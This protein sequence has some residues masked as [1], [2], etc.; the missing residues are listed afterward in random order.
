M[1]NLDNEA[2]IRKKLEKLKKKIEK[3]F[4]DEAWFFPEINGVK[5]Y[6]GTGLCRLYD[7]RIMFIAER[8]STKRR[9]IKDL[10][11]DAKLMLFYDL[12]ENLNL[13]MPT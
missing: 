5:G 13:K 12:L 2:R 1:C 8:P 11:N 6:Y 4:G 3:R 10:V 7:K 9:S